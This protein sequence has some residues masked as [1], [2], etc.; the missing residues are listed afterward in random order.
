MTPSSPAPPFVW[1]T[2]DASHCARMT[3]RRYICRSPPPP[4]QQGRRKDPQKYNTIQPPCLAAHPDGRRLEQATKSAPT[5]CQKSGGVFR[6]AE[7]TLPATPTSGPDTPSCP[8]HPPQRGWEQAL[9]YT[10]ITPV[11]SPLF[12]LETR[13]PSGQEEVM[14]PSISMKHERPLTS[15]TPS[16]CARSLHLHHVL[17]VSTHPTP[18]SAEFPTYSLL[19]IARR[20]VVS[21]PV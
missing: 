18:F 5:S 2:N 13:H 1:G 19:P 15:T 21:C 16:K 17:V 20:H 14:L 11:R 10:T 3:P 6:S 4:V 9:T 12:P 7:S 8:A